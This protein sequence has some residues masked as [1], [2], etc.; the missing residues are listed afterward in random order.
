MSFHYEPKNTQISP[1]FEIA[2]TNKETKQQIRMQIPRSGI[3]HEAKRLTTLRDVKSLARKI[4]QVL[5]T[6][7]D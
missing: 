5:K 2:F 7:L 1:T 6:E 4:V 3:F